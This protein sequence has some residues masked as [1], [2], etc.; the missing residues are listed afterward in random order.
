MRVA[1]PANTI[2]H[3]T[4]ILRLLRKHGSQT[5]R[6]LSTLTGYSISLIRQ[7][8]K[9]LADRGLIVEDGIAN[10]DS[11]G[12]PSQVWSI[13]PDACYALGLDVG[14]SFTRVAVLNAVGEVIY[15]HTQPTAKAESGSLLLRNLND[16]VNATIHSMNGA[17]SSIRGLGVAFSGFVDYKLGESIDA[18]NIDSAQH[19]PIQQY[20]QQSTGLPVIVD[21]SSRAAAIAEMRYGAA[22]DSENFV[23]I[24]IGAGI[25]TGIIVHGQLYRG[26]EGLAGELGHIPMMIHGERCRCGS[27]GC[28]ETLSSGRAIADKARRMLEHNVPSQLHE[29]TDND[30][31][32]ATAALVTKAALNGDKLANDL[33]SDAGAWLGMAL[34]TAVNLFSP[35]KVILTG[36]VMRGNPLLLSIVRDSAHKYILRQLPDLPILLTELDEFAGALG[37]ATFV[38]DAEF[39]NGFARRLGQLTAQS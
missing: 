13:S 27:Q 29:L 10:L 37:A 33:L 1:D 24:N 4:E 16:L 23:G 5:R 28:L 3:Q 26:A 30:P 36:G 9:D 17:G 32:K 12:R 19:L 15:K 14:G 11:P 21:D 31:S 2:E 20:L 8:T 6:R 22:Q 39:E 18:P 34:A 35:E 38:L 25:G 7:L